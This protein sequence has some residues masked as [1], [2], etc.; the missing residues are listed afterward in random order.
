MISPDN[1]YIHP[2]PEQLATVGTQTK[3]GT[4]DHFLFSDIM[5]CDSGTNYGFMM[6]FLFVI[7]SLIIQRS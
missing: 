3:R 2:T 6:Y 1:K 4:Y 5:G 7:G